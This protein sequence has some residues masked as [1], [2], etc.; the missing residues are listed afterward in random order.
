VRELQALAVQ[1]GAVD[2]ERRASVLVCLSVA[3]SSVAKNGVSHFLELGA[4]LVRV[5][6]LGRDAQVGG[7]FA[8]AQNGHACRTRLLIVIVI[9][10][11]RGG[12]D[13]QV[14]GLLVR[15]YRAADHGF[16]RALDL[17]LRHGYVEVHQCFGVARD[18]Q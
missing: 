14:Y 17:G 6:G 5:A 15:G 11:V 12:D 7:A 1:Q 10:F 2:S 18:Q 4:D 13:R 16:E 3:V 8:P 9:G